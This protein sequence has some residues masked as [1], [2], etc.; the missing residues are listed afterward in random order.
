MRRYFILSFAILLLCGCASTQQTG[1]TA[2]NRRNSN[3]VTA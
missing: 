1:S 2:S 3:L